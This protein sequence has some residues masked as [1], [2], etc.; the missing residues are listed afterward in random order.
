MGWVFSLPIIKTII[1]K[2]IDSNFEKLDKAIYED[3]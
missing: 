1:K 3:M 2:K